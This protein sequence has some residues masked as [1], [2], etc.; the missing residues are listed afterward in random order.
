METGTFSDGFF[1]VLAAVS[2]ALLTG[3][4]LNSQANRI[5]NA[6]R[7]LT[8]SILQ[9]RQTPG[10]PLENLLKSYEEAESLIGDY[11]PKVNAQ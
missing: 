11:S 2:I 9:F 1:A 7:H 3:L 10:T 5:R 6:E 8:F 4:D